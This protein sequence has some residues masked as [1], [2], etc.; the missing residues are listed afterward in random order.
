[1][2]VTGL[3]LSLTVSRP[4]AGEAWLA[5]LSIQAQINAKS[6]TLTFAKVMKAF[7]ES[8]NAPKEAEVLKPAKV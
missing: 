2:G 7:N 6:E 4:H 5:P 3:D 1:M 8:P